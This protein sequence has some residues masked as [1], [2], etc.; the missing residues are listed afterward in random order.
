[1]CKRFAK[2][3]TF[4]EVKDL[5]PCSDF[6]IYDMSPASYANFRAETNQRVLLNQRPMLVPHCIV[7]F[8]GLCSDFWFNEEH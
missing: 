1:M 5:S 3:H 2:S 8:S 6:E 7:D 4:A